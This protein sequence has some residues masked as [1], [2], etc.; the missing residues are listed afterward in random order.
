MWILLFS[1]ALLGYAHGFEDKTITQY[2]ADNGYTT[3]SSALAAQGLDT[4]LAGTGKVLLALK[5]SVIFVLLLMVLTKRKYY[6]L[7]PILYVI[8]QFLEQGYL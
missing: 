6:D 8:R 5:L 3:L 4:V 2:L 1:I 7:S